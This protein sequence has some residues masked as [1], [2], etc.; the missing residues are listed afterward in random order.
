MSK[1]RV[2]S[3]RAGERIE[4]KACHGAVFVEAFWL[5]PPT[6]DQPVFLSYTPEQAVRLA[7]AL[8]FEAA[9]ASGD[10]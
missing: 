6:T 4:V 7:H 3:D 5:K 8:I 10:L 1:L 9:S 2:I